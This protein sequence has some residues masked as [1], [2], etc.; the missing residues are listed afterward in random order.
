[1]ASEFE[2]AFLGSVPIDPMFVSLIEEGKTP[3]YPQG[4]VVAGLD[5][6]S[7]EDKRLP[8]T[9]GGDQTLAEKYRHCSLAPI[10]EDIASKLIITSV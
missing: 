1:M 9:E 2:V 3:T 8:K 4:T 5:L 7:S 6:G 10:F